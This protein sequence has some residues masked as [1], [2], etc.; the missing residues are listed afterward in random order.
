VLIAS[1]QLG[2]FREDLVSVLGPIL[3]TSKVNS[4]INSLEAE[5]RK[6]AEAGARQAIPDIRLQVREEATSAVK[7][8]AIAAI[9]AGGLGLIVGI[10]AIWRTRGRKKR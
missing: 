7:P 6:Q 9:A 4:F 5:I 2:G 3:G 10:V 8:L 1:S